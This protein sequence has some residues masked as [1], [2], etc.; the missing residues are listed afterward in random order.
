M[1]LVT[2]FAGKRLEIVVLWGM[3]RNDNYVSL[4]LTFKPDYLCECFHTWPY[5]KSVKYIIPIV[6]VFKLL[7]VYQKRKKN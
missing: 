1:Y 4:Y 2:E 5:N 3:V 7:T 6:F